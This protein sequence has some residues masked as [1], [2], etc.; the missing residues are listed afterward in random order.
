MLK[1]NVVPYIQNKIGSYD[2]SDGSFLYFELV[3]EWPIV[4][5]IKK[6]TVD[7]RTYIT[8]S[9][10]T[11]KKNEYDFLYGTVLVTFSSDNLSFY[12][13]FK[14]NIIIDITDEKYKSV[15]EYMVENDLKVDDYESFRAIFMMVNI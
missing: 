2:P 11:M 12:I 15:I 7:E 6:T 13:M 10:Y 4:K 8:Q 1:L 3:V 5:V 9:S 14:S